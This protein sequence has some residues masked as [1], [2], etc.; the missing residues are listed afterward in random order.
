MNAAL[1]ASHERFELAASCS[2]DGMWDYDAVTNKIWRS[3]RYAEMYGYSEEEADAFE[4]HWAFGARSSCR[5]MPSGRA[6]SM[7][8]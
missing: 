1:T 4:D 3:P 5:K 7:T 8:T 6:A 2:Q